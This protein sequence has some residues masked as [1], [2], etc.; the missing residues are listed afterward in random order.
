MS[1]TAVVLVAVLQG[2]GGPP[3]PSATIGRYLSAWSD[4][5]YG[6]MASLVVRPP[7][8]F[9]AFN[10]RIAD[11]LDLERAVYRAGPVTESGSGATVAVTGHLVVTPFGPLDVRTGLRLTEADGS[12]RVLWSPRSIIPTLG[13]GD[14]VSTTVSWPA[15]AAVLGAAGAP[16]TVEAPMVTVG[17]EGSRITGVPAV[18]AALAQAGATA[19]E[20]SAALATATAH[21]LWF[22]P[23][24][25]I[26]EARYQVLKPVIYPVPGTVFRTSSARTAITPG[27]AAHVV[28]SV[29]PVTAQELRSLGPPYQ[30]GD[31]VGQTG[32]EQAYERQLA[33]R[34]GGRIA[35]VDAAGVPV[36]T[37]ARFAALS[38]IA[39][40]H[41]PRPHRPAGGRGGAER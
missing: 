27:L 16:L 34:P 18:T 10:R 25:E 31:T 35:V 22:V 32:I 11:E 37:V 2:C 9:V 3:G 1:L 13:P 24:V 17:I 29:G 28:G 30:A 15:R 19:A 14:A 41:H 21:P 12:W 6:A 38:R 23:V 26:P 7:P 33:G 8:D 40:P 20:V 36:A 4:G 5:D 39:G